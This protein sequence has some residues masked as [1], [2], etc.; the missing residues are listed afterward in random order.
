MEDP[1][2]EAQRIPRD[3]RS[4]GPPGGEVAAGEVAVV[5][6]RAVVRRV[7]GGD[8]DVCRIPVEETGVVPSQAEAQ[9]PHV[10]GHFRPVEAAF[11]GEE[12]RVPV[13]DTARPQGEARE[14]P[15]GKL[16]P[17]ELREV[18]GSFI[19]MIHHRPGGEVEIRLLP[20]GQGEPGGQHG[21]GEDPLSLP[22]TRLE[23]FTDD[24]APVGG[25]RGGEDQYEEDREERPDAAR[26][27]GPIR[28][29]IP[30]PSR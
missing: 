13:V 5:Q 21:F 3:S 14:G 18:F 26:A 4:A 1:F 11:G 6:F 12:G 27:A 2:P 23:L 24:D 28:H 7:A 30:P 16:Q 9:G 20:Q 29:R 15:E 17:E 25:Q 8:A 19:V 10:Q 22:E